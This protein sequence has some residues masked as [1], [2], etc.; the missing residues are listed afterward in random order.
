M[1]KLNTAIK[2][3]CFIIQLWLQQHERNVQFVFISCSFP[4]SANIP[5]RLS[6]LCFNRKAPYPSVSSLCRFLREL[7]YLRLTPAA[8]SRASNI[9]LYMLGV[10]QPYYHCFLD[11]RCISFGLLTVTILDASTDSSNRATPITDG[12]HS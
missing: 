5:P 3:L 8:H 1:N 12:R 11:L 10:L 9:M 4:F 6:I 2:M 7:R